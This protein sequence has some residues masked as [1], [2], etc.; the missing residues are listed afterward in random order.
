M[1]LT[2]LCIHDV[3]F[4]VYDRADVD[5]CEYRS[6]VAIFLDIMYHPL[7][8]EEEIWSLAPERSFESRATGP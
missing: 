4:I 3:S 8:E 7:I 5:V 2:V 1:Y 6:S